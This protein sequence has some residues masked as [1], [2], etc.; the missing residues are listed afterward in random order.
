MTRISLLEL[1]FFPLNN[2]EWLLK[3]KTRMMKVMRKHLASAPRAKLSDLLGRSTVDHVVSALK[4]TI[5]TVPGLVIAWASITTSS[6]GISYS[7]LFLD[8][9]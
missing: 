5:T 1:T 4:S 6:S 8:A 9:L 2:S 7:M 3:K